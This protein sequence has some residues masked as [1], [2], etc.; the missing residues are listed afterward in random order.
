MATFLLYIRQK[1]DTGNKTDTDQIYRD[2]NFKE[3]VHVEQY[4]KGR[5]WPLYKLCSKISVILEYTIGE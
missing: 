3:N 1:R 4:M 2:T 5:L